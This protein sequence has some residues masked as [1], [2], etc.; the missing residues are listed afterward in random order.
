MKNKLS[1]ISKLTLVGFI[2]TLS[3]S[4]MITIWAL[5]MDSFFHNMAVVGFF[6]AI[7]GII[8][9][10]SYFS[11][12]PLIERSDK[13]K[14]YAFS[15]F[16][17]FIS[18]IL[19]AVNKN[20][21][22]FILLAVLIS[23]LFTLRNS[24]FGIIVRDKSKRE[25]LSKNEGFIYT[26]ANLS[27]VVGPLIA[28]YIASRAG[29]PS[30]FLFSSI[31]V[32]FALVGFKLSKI[33]DKNIKKKTDKKIIKNFTSFFK[34]KNRV[35]AYCLELGVS[36][37]WSLIY[38]FIPLFMKRNNLSEFRIGIFLF[39]VALPLIFLEYLFAKK[40]SVI[41]FKKIFKI[42]FLIPAALILVCFFISNIYYILS[43]IVLASVG[44]AMLEP[45][46]EAY[47]FDLL[48]NK[49]TLRYYSPFLTSINTGKIISKLVSSLILLV[50]P[51]RFI[52]LFYALVMFSLFFISFKTKN[53]IES[54]RKRLTIKKY[55]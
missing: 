32:F 18:F 16:L 2:S 25:D 41:G 29:I 53:I 11:I 15:L 40:A 43:L 24:S 19:F 49:Q 23:V 10:I 12:I 55:R 42:G 28:G 26:F 39:A 50:L 45:T 7:L 17:F 38:I 3:L 47:F 13:A 4:A 21:I 36:F 52:F 46:I 54:R 1:D 5:Y 33:K 31:I 22:V 27:W 9:F 34:N 35:I 14:L 44:L 20:L 37:W 48:N 8:S 6:S 30:V 51:F